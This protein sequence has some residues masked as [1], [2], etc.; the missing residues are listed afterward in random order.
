MF[1]ANIL[2]IYFHLRLVW[3]CGISQPM[4]IVGFVSQKGGVGKST[5]ARALA[6][7][8][9]REDL[10]VK[11]A[12]L[13]PQQ[14]TAVAWAMRRMA[15]GIEPA[16]AAEPFRNVSDAL[17]ACGGL[18]LLILD[19]PARA[20]RETLAIAKA[21]DLLIQP[22]GTAIDD[23]DPAIRLFHE[24]VAAGVDRGRLVIVLSRAGT[25]AEERD[26][27]DYVTRAGFEVLPGALIERAGYRQAQ[28]A[29][30][31]VQEARHTALATRAQELMK[32]ISDRI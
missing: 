31:A 26:A 2:F 13:D 16:I 3:T 10:R 4:L 27:R 32:A 19:G 8:G 11:I 17:A 20:S 14:G 5:L 21:S 1:L 9:V 25:E 30:F 24:L 23:L 7:E 15:S 29:G 6:L 12:D 18:D 22:S 28:N